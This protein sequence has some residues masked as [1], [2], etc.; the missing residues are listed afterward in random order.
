[1]EL[2]VTMAVAP[3]AASDG[4]L[5]LQTDQ[6]YTVTLDRAYL[7]LGAVE[8]HGCEK[9]G[10]DALR[11]WFG[12][13]L[14]FAHTLSSPTRIGE[15]VVLSLLADDATPTDIGTL[16]PPPGD[17]CVTH[18]EFQPAD[19]D[20]R[21]LPSDIDIVGATLDVAGAWSN[22]DHSGQEFA[23]RTS[24]RSERELERCFGLS[25]DER[26]RTLG[27]RAIVEHAF[28]GVDFAEQTESEQAR[29]VLSN[30]AQGL[31]AGMR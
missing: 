31:E 19:G 30:I 10:A 11:R 17:Y 24:S 5:R 4:S 9:T 3:S 26:R 13:K 8:I 6:G 15:P 25:R 2:T 18:V 29:T 27:L 20:A 21:G 14:A 23:L 28:D 12:P 1:M 16:L 22:A 7:N